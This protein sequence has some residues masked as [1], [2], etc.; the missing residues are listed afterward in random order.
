M[1]ITVPNFVHISQSVADISTFFDFYDGG[2]PPCW[3]C[4]TGV[5][6]THEAYLVVF[7]AVQNLVGIGVVVLNICDF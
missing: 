1:C 4:F 6:I 5:W 2:H 7:I 3:I